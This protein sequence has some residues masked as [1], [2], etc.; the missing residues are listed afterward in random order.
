MGKLTGQ[1]EEVTAHIQAQTPHATAKIKQQ[2][3]QDIEVTASSMTPTSENITRTVVEEVHHD[4]Q[5]Q[6]EQTPVD[7]QWREAETRSQV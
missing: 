1:V 7:A 4:V 5:A 3:E 2:L 6:F